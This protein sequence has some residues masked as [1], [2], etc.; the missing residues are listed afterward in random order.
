LA[1][2]L[3]WAWLAVLKKSKARAI[4]AEGGRARPVR[5]EVRRADL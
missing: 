3:Q 4:G 5:D 1:K 2:A